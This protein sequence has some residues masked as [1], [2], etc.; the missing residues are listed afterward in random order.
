MSRRVAVALAWVAASLLIAASGWRVVRPGERI[1]VRR[2]GRIVVPDW[3]PGLHWG[4][5][6]GIDRFDRVRTDEVRRLNVGAAQQA[7]ADGDP[8][9]DEFLTGDLNLVRVRAVIQYRV[10]S[11]AELVVRSGDV[12]VLLARLAEA[13]LSH[14]LARRGIDPVLKGDRQRIGAEVARDLEEAIAR[15]RL[16]LEI[17]GVSLTEARPPAEVAADF[18]AAQSAES[19]RDRRGNEA[20]TQ[21]ET[22]VTAA[23][24][25]V[26]TR[27]ETAR[28]ASQRKLLGSRAGAQRFLA[29]LAEARRSPELTAQRIYLDTMKTLLGR[30]RR[31]IILPPGDF[32]DLTV[33][34]IEE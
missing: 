1:V 23:R 5:P 21:A 26:G 33:L 16:G 29:L 15:L 2:F 4:A 12:A 20:R 18:S 8:G 14:S 30:V 28:A 10:A 19:Q 25:T 34:G 13:S 24:A 9:A 6:L 27:L 32:V 22:T 3:G 7:A 11:P 31:K 17:L